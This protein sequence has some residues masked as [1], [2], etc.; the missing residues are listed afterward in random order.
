MKIIDAKEISKNT[1]VNVGEFYKD[2]PTT[3]VILSASDDKAS[4]VYVDKKQK[5]FEEVGVNCL[6]YDLDEYTTTEDMIEEIQKFNEDDSVTGIMV[7]HPVY[8]G[9]DFREVVSAIDPRK[10]I[11]G[12]HPFNQGMKNYGEHNVLPATS[13]GVMNIIDAN[14]IDVKGKFV[15]IVGRGFLVADPLA[16]AL[17]HR[18][19]T[20][21][22]I[23]TKTDVSDKVD[24]FQMADI[25]IPCAGTDL[26]DWINPDECPNAEVLIGVGF[27]YIDG[28]QY[29]DFDMEDWKDV[30]GLMTNRINS[31][32]LAT[33]SALLVNSIICY[34]NV[35]E[36]K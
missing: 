26:S 11:D 16:K 9:I 20:V 6:V 15:V 29:Q 35:K 4:E 32:G 23:H 19:A 10:D 2:R 7:Q 18:G 24:L 12:L 17:E 8:K 22:K 25:I 3:V 33:I 14:E 5:A 28:K 21:V 31:T 1:I 13:L 30:D 27:R 36:G 34:I